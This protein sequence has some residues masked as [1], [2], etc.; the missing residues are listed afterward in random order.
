MDG[1]IDYRLKIEP[2]KRIAS[3]RPILS[4]QMEVCACL[5]EL[6]DLMVSEFGDRAINILY[7]SPS[8][9]PA[10]VELCLT[11]DLPIDTEV[12]AAVHA[13]LS[14]CR[15]I[16]LES[17]NRLKNPATFN[18]LH[19]KLLRKEKEFTDRVFRQLNPTLSLRKESLAKIIVRLS[20][21]TI[22]RI[23]NPNLIYVDSAGEIVFLCENNI[24]FETLLGPCR[25]DEKPYHVVFDIKRAPGKK[26]TT[27][28][29]LLDNKKIKHE[30]KD[31]IFWSTWERGGYKF[32]CHSTMPAYCRINRTHDSV[33]YEIVE[34]V[35]ILPPAKLG[36]QLPLAIMADS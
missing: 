33:S 18:E 10:D 24:E 14:C 36:S 2:D 32:V 7:K 31:D 26:N 8:G 5:E 34:V 9:C 22:G 4:G 27:F 29:L 23:N 17:L 1:I 20:S 25:N 15:R 16:V 6:D 11:S 3:Y 12:Y 30:I 21:I 13:H 19:K 28:E 35:D